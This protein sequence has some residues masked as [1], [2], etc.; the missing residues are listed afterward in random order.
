MDL[1]SI[2][3]EAREE[4]NKFT[5]RTSNRQAYNQ[6]LYL[7]TLSA[8]TVSI[9]PGESSTWVIF[10]FGCTHNGFATQALRYGG[11]RWQV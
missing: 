1:C 8:G 5:H 9:G 11:S 4:D 3:F 2:Y 6:V 10:S 7:V